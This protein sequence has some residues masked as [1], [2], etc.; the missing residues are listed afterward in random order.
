MW[1]LYAA[2]TITSIT[3]FYSLTD[4]NKY[5]LVVY[6]LACLHMSSSLTFLIC[7]LHSVCENGDGNV[8]VTS[9]LLV[10]IAINLV[11]L[12]GLIRGKRLNADG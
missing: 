4:A 5:R 1:L 6:V 7:F 3:V 8:L 9:V 11:L 2:A 10:S 12:L